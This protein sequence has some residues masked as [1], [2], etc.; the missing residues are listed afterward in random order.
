M[1]QKHGTYSS[2][3][4]E[5]QAHL[6]KLSELDGQCPTCEQEIDEDKL[7]AITKD[8]LN[9]KDEAYMHN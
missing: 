5:A 9:R 2:K 7:E 3:L 8:Y 6:D 1:L 4:S